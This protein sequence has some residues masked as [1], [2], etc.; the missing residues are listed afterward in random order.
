TA[1]ASIVA[2]RRDNALNIPAE[3]VSTV[4]GKSVVQIVTTDSKGNNQVAQQT[5]EPGLRAGDRIEIVSGL[6]E[7]QQV[8][9]SAV[10]RQP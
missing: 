7:G 1:S 8:L 4:D 9:P 6:S 2:A 10:S 5:V 3:A